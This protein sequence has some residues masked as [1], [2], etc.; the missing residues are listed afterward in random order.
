MDIFSIREERAGQES[1]LD[2]VHLD[3]RIGPGSGSGPGDRSAD[4][5]DDYG[6]SE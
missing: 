4:C 3:G 6:V 1:L 2:P 5:W